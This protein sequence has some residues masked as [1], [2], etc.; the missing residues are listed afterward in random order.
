VGL[1]RGH[2]P[3]G[4]VILN[5][6]DVLQLA[7]VLLGPDMLAGFGVDQLAGDADAV[8]RRS[9]TALQDIANSELPGDLPDIH[10]FAL[11]M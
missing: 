4:D 2:D 3:F 5:G 7:V 11:V 6:E 1:H 9:D 10:G 8:A